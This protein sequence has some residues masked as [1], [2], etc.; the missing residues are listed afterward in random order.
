VEVTFDAE[1]KGIVLVGKLIIAALAAAAASLGATTTDASSAATSIR[2]TFVLWNEGPGDVE[3]QINLLAGNGKMGR[4]VR[5]SQILPVQEGPWGEPVHL[6][7]S[8]SQALWIQVHGRAYVVRG[9]FCSEI[10]PDEVKTLIVFGE[11]RERPVVA[12]ED[13]D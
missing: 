1:G 9:N 12:A 13:V 10:H 2:P 5:A 7:G 11:S 4:L 3:V 6:S 8:C